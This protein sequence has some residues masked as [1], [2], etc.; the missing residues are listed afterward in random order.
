MSTPIAWT[1][2]KEGHTYEIQQVTS[3]D[4]KTQTR[5]G[6]PFVRVLGGN[7]GIAPSFTPGSQFETKE[8]DWQGRAYI[9]RRL[10]FNYIVLRELIPEDAFK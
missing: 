2:V 10:C 3:T 7:R 1:D 9:M 8:T 4:V 6:Q 5:L